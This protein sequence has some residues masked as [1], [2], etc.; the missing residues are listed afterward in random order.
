MID[1]DPHAWHAHLLDIKGSMVREILARV[2]TCVGWSAVVV[3]A[4][5]RYPWLIAPTTVHTL[6]G[7]AL[8]LLLVFRTSSSNDRYTEG[9]KLWGGIVNECRSLNMAA[10]VHLAGDPDLLARVVLWTAAFPYS[11]MR[12]LRSQDGLGPPAGRL[13]EDEVRR[14]LDSSHTPS[15]VAREI[16]LGLAE[17]RRRGSLNDPLHS[18][19][20]QNVQRLIDL[21][22]GCE[23]IRSTPL[24]FV[25]VVHLRR[26]LILYCYTLPLALVDT[27]GWLTVP[28]TL[29]LAYTF[30]GIEE[31]GVEIEDPFGF[32]C[33]DL[34]LDQICAKIEANLLTEPLPQLVEPAGAAA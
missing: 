30:F 31:I 18:V 6:V 5:L 23:R 7:V 17:A 12:A 32:D 26:A 15:S 16:A 20:E 19:L 24:P 11:C 22:G 3:L 14:A 21:I 13:P 2:L 25:Y 28:A 8:G 9:R 27:Y 1:Y 29:L 33:N 10:R 34:P 4:H